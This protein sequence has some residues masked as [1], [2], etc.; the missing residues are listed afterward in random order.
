M[1]TMTKTTYTVCTTHRVI[2]SIDGTWRRDL[3][4]R[5]T[6]YTRANAQGIE[7]REGV[8]PACEQSAQYVFRAQWAARYNVA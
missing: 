4:Q 6:S 8:C 5:I 2:R 1:A 3:Y 7:L